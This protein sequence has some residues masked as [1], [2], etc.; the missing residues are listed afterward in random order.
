MHYQH[1][2]VLA[3]LAAAGIA[4]SC[5]DVRSE[6][7]D[8]QSYHA[9]TA[10]VI[11]KLDARLADATTT[12]E[13]LTALRAKGYASWRECVE[14]RVVIE[15]CEA[16]KRAVERFAAFSSA[17]A[18]RLP[19]TDR[20]DTPSASAHVIKTSLVESARRIAGDE[21]QAGGA[22]RM[23][24]IAQRRA[25][26]LLD[27]LRQL[28]AQGCASAKE[29]QVAQ[30]ELASVTKHVEQLK[31]RHFRLVQVL[32]LRQPAKQ[33]TVV[34]DEQLTAV[35]LSVEILRHASAV[36]HLLSLRLQRCIEE[37]RADSVAA[38]L[39]MLEEVSRRLD[40]T[41]KS[42]TPR[43]EREFAS[44]DVEYARAELEDAT[45]RAAILGREEA[46][47]VEQV[48]QPS[49]AANVLLTSNGAD[50]LQ[51]GTYW[52]SPASADV[53]H[54]GEASYFLYEPLANRLSRITANEY[55]PA[56][57]RIWPS[58]Q[59]PSN[60]PASNTA[61]T[62]PLPFYPNVRSTY[63]AFDRPPLPP[64]PYRV[65][66]YGDYYQ[67]GNLRPDLPKLEPR[68]TGYGGPWFYP[69]ASTN[70]R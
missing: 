13:K 29:V 70:F 39:K 9:Q 6:T 28:H 36:D 62:P 24:E 67:F 30:D 12:L 31:A 21:A 3:L 43:R 45:Q 49:A 42:A 50:D 37:A 16:Q 8:P 68:A 53:V 15:S 33:E 58:L 34:E 51:L 55:N 46:R 40:K 54:Q 20:R 4:M 18:K 2:T 10:E 61:N 65:P 57:S 41:L 26:L 23:A 59:R 66:T 63:Y 11:R 47:F 25:T 48:S 69:G 56:P 32:D 5:C 44:L 52:E 22:L 7:A 14:Q 35:S 1:R 38:K 27:S 60:Q 17:V 64:S 19:P